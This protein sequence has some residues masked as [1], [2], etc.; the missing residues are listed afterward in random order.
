MAPQGG[1]GVKLKISVTSTLTV[2]AGIKETDFPE[3]EKAMADV[4]GHDSTGGW[5]EH[6]PTGKR[7]ANP[8]TCTVFWDESNNTHAAIKTA[9]DGE[10]P[11]NMSIED[12]DG[13]E[14]IAFA[15]HITKMGR[16][17][18]QEDAFMCEIEIQPTG[19][20]TIS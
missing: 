3:F 14:V 13:D 9:F 10:A 1:F 7:M 18:E 20:V 12:P 11:V 4:T 19:A 17:S 8:F 6:L 16:V 15:A 2:I 5:A